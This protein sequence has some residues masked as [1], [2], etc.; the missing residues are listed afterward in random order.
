MNWKVKA[1]MIRLYINLTTLVLFKEKTDVN[2]SNVKVLQ[3]PLCSK[4]PSSRLLAVLFMP[5]LHGRFFS[6]VGV[7]F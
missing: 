3:R 7:F 4:H 6:S 2:L 5:G 1:K